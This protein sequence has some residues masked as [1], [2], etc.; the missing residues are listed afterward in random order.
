ML[1]E[2]LTGVFG[3]GYPNS[4][5]S[6]LLYVIVTVYSA[7]QYCAVDFPFSTF[8]LCDLY[9]TRS[10]SGYFRPVSS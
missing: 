3:F 2:E 10:F 1:C 8:V 5:Y 6:L 9:V 4:D 7:N